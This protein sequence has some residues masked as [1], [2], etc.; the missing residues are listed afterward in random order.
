M[1]ILKE[2]MGEIEEAFIILSKAYDMDPH[3]KFLL[4]SLCESLQ[5]NNRI[6]EAEHILKEMIKSNP[7]IEF[8]YLM[9]ANLLIKDN[10]KK[11]A[12]DLLD[13]YSIEYPKLYKFLQNVIKLNQED[14]K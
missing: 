4:V 14:T 9:I 8:Q 13:Y 1:A 3:N 5:K 10:R 2:N 7:D 6:T 11:E 12:L